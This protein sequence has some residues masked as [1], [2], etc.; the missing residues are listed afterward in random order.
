[1]KF[2]VCCQIKTFCRRKVLFFLSET[3]NICRAERYAVILFGIIFRNFTAVP[4]AAEIEVLRT[5]RHRFRR[6]FKV[7]RTKQIPHTRTQRYFYFVFAV[8]EH[9]CYIALTIERK[10]SFFAVR[11]DFRGHKPAA[12]IEQ[13]SAPFALFNLTRKRYFAL[14]ERV[15]VLVKSIRYRRHTLSL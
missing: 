15:A 2:S 11:A 7:V 14:K 10:Q 6:R 8:F 4:T 13:R 1:M 12:Y 3:K 5:Y 9:I